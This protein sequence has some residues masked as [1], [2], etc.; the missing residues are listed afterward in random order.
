MLRFSVWVETEAIN[1]EKS[2]PLAPLV[3]VVITSRNKIF[4]RLVFLSSP[5]IGISNEAGAAK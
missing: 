4:I 5:P 1:W 3:G 2:A